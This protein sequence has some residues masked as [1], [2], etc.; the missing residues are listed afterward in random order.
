MVD[1][2]GQGYSNGGV[3]GAAVGEWVSKKFG[4][5]WSITWRIAVWLLSWLI[6]GILIRFGFMIADYVTLWYTL[7]RYI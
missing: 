7:L 3:L 4:T 5:A 1:D 2:L 6:A